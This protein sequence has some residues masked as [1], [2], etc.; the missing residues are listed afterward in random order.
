MKIERPV[1]E[2]PNE[3][4]KTTPDLATDASQWVLAHGDTLY[5]FA[6]MRVRDSSVAEELMQETFLAALKGIQ[7]FRGR[8]SARTWLIGILKHKV[9]DHLR[10]ACREVPTEDIDMEVDAYFNDRGGWAVPPSIVGNP[11]ENVEQ[12]ELRGKLA[13]CMQELPERLSRVFVL[14]Q[15]DGLSAKETCKVLGITTTNLWVM[16]YRARLRLQRCLQNWY[17]E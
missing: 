14:T 4:A 15:I 12:E 9:M 3:N 17:S 10:H 8:S 5:R 6:L 1:S 2:P 7:E 13:E 16:L 11:A